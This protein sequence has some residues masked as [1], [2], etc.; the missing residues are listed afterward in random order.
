MEK[1]KDQILPYL[2]AP[3]EKELFEAALVNLNDSN[4]KLR[5]NNFAYAMRELTRHFLARLAPDGEV[6][7]APWF[8]ANDPDHPDKVTRGQRIR[9]AIQGYLTDEYREKTLQISLVEISRNLIKSIDG[10]NKY[11]HVNSDT[12]NVDDSTISDVSLNILEDTLHFF[13]TIT[14]TQ[15]RIMEAVIDCV[16]EEMVSQFYFETQNEIDILA[17]HHEVLHYTITYLKLLG[18]DDETI[19]MRA[20]GFVKVRLQYGSDSDIRKDIGYE[21]TINLPFSSQCVANYKNQNGDIHL[22]DSNI[23]IDTDDF[24]K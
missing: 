17:T 19:T 2:K 14:E 23:E 10:L 5:L 12:F 13:M 11:T 22:I 16:D 8:E 18:K 6:L 20:D 21:T 1:I 24:F 4:N 15:L 7:K 3:F 9:Y